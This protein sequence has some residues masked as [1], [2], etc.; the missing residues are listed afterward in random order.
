M[1]GHLISYLANHLQLLLVQ[2]LRL[3]LVV[4]IVFRRVGVRGIRVEAIRGRVIGVRVLSI[5]EVVVG[6]SV[7]VDVDEVGEVFEDVGHH[8]EL[9]AGWGA[10]YFM[11]SSCPFIVCETRRK[12]LFELS[13][14]R[15]VDDW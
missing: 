12:M 5:A 13:G 7:D 6:V 1:F 10:G 8:V 4:V 2:T 3:L 9:V 14:L 15:E 11:N